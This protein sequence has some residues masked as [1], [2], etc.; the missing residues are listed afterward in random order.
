MEQEEKIICTQCGK[1]LVMH[2]LPV[3]EKDFCSS[4]CMEKYKREKGDR[5]FFVEMREALKEMGDRWIPKYADEYMR[6]CVGWTIAMRRGI[7]PAQ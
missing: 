3:K 5:K 1:D 2:I 4:W 6:M 7:W